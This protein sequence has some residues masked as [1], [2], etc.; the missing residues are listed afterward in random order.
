MKSLSVREPTPFR[1]FPYQS[2]EKAH[3]TPARR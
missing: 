1:H 3:F 2:I